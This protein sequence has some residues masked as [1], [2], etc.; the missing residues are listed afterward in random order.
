[1]VIMYLMRFSL[2]EEPKSR[3]Y[4]KSANGV[5]IKMEL[6]GVEPPASSLRTIR[7]LYAIF[8]CF[9]IRTV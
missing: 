3:P 8:S 9:N 6:K 2:G 4:F 1:M 7:L 5:R